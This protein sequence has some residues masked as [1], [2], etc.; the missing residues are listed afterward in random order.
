MARMCVK[1]SQRHKI[2]APDDT[3]AFYMRQL[4]VNRGLFRSLFNGRLL[5][6]SALNS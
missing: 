4:F 2:K 6:L 3:G 5:E 1:T